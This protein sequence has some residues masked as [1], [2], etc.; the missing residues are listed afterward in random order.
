MADTSRYTTSTQRDNDGSFRNSAE[1]QFQRAVRHAVRMCPDLTKSERDVT[2]AL[3]NH[4]VHHRAKGPIHPGRQRIAKKAD[5]TVKTVSRCFAMLRAAGVL[6][7]VK[8]LRGGYGSATRYRFDL[9]ALMVLVGCDWID[10]FRGG[11][12]GTNVPV[13]VGKMSRL[14]RDK[15]SH[16]IIGT[17]DTSTEANVDACSST[18][19]DGESGNV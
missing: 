3:F 6:T 19:K 9:V 7:P 12:T 10:D 5:V 4:W 1:A 16:G 13:V 11:S 15:M 17:S 14:L 2:L 8:N 18:S